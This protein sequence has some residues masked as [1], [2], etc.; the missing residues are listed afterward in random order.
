MLDLPTFTNGGIIL[1]ALVAIGG[2][3]AMLL[4]AQLDRAHRIVE[5]WPS[6][7]IEMPF[8]QCRCGHERARHFGGAGMCSRSACGCQ[9]FRAGSTPRRAA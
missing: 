5:E 7:A 3:V 2:A 6:R 1:L 4:A 9:T 8:E